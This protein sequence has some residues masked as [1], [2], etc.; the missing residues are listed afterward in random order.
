MFEKPGLFGFTVQDAGGFLPD[1][2]RAAG[3]GWIAIQVH[4]SVTRVETTDYRAFI[5]PYR[6]KGVEVVGWG[7]VR[8]HPED[9]ANLAVD[10]CQELDLHAFIADAEEEVGFT[11]RGVPTPEAFGRSD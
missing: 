7:V 1:E 2:M 11:Q 4:D 6:S 9:E 8:E 5:S 3:F 10:L